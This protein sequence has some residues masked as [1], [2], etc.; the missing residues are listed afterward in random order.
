MAIFEKVCSGSLVT[1]KSVVGSTVPLHL[2]KLLHS[3]DATVQARAAQVLTAL[4]R[5]RLVGLV[6]GEFVGGGVLKAA[7]AV[8]EGG[9]AA[10]PA[11]G[12]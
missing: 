12:K 7:E 11:A 6:L 9:C 5:G 10:N 3:N 2:A 4:D 8:A 1:R